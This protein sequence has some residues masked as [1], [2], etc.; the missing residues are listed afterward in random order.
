MKRISTAIAALLAVGLA[1][2]ALAQTATD[3][4]GMAVGPGASF[5]SSG[6]NAGVIGSGS[7]GAPSLNL[8]RNASSGIGI[9]SGV[10][11]GLGASTGDCPFSIQILCLPLPGLES[12]S[13][14]SGNF[15]GTR[16]GGLVPG[17]IN[18][19][20]APENLVSGSSLSGLGGSNAVGGGP[21]QAGGSTL[22]S[23]SVIG[24]ANL[25]TGLT[26]V[27]NTITPPTTTAPIGA[28][29]PMPGP[30]AGGGSGPGSSSSGTSGFDQAFCANDPLGC[31]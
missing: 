2:G 7:I 22:G 19:P 4:F 30:S 12:G 11:L 6:G 8:P 21:T 9:G 10:G 5:G 18:V 26:G 3:P 24:G 20:V 1:G 13:A 14:A 27:I 31:L 28:S 16:G 17:V 25:S 23:S 29:P 15:V